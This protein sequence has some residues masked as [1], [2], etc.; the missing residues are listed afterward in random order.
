MQYRKSL[1]GA[2][3][4]ATFGSTVSAE[5]SWDGFYAGLSL[6]AT[7][8]AASIAGTNAHDRNTRSAGIGA[9]AGFNR[10]ARSGLV[11]GGELG[12]SPIDSAANKTGGGLGTSEFKGTYLIT[13]R[14]RAGFTTGN[15]FLYGTAGFGISNATMRS[16]PAT[17]KE[18]VVGISY[19]IGAEMKLANNWST[20]LDISRTDLGVSGQS[21]NGQSRKTSVMI[22]KITFGLSK[23]F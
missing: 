12:I 13:P 4:L 6:E 16:S 22:D 5:P 3:C 17:T 20:R 23:N 18:M 11:W 1:I 21:F 9:Y 7:R 8:G 10:T 2:L 14:M 15:L 19:G